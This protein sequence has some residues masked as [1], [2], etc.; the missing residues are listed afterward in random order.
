L[1]GVALQALQRLATAR[2]HAGAVR[3]EVG[4]AS[5]PDRFDLFTGRLLRGGQIHHCDRRCQ[6]R[7]RQQF[8]DATGRHAIP[9]NSES[10]QEAHRSEPRAGFD[11]ESIMHLLG[12]NTWHALTSPRRR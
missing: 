2:L 1:R 7:E 9:P 5:V 12:E 6:Q 10:G 3:D 8:A 4:P 11:E